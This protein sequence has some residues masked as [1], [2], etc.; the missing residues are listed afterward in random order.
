[1]TIARQVL[2]KYSAAVT[3]E[4]IFFTRFNIVKRKKAALQKYAP[5][6]RAKGV[7]LKWVNSGTGLNAVYE[8][9]MQSTVARL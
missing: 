3:P 5:L 2:A 1:M 8:G 6:L 9:D 7:D 4:D